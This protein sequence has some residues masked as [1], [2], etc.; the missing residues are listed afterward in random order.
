MSSTQAMTARSLALDLLCKTLRQKQFSNI[1]LDKALQSCELSDADKRLASLLFYGVIEKK[2]TLDFRISQLSARPIGDIDERTLCA[3]R[4]G[5][6]QLMFT[7]KIPPHAAINETVSLC[8]RR[9]AGFRMVIFPRSGAGGWSR[10]CP[11]PPCF[12]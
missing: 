11:R 6:Y 4:L 7:D 12:R 3:L 9:S 5:L 2:I 10:S 8:P 1:A